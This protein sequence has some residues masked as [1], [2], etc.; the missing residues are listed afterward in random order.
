M[1]QAWLT[2]AQWRSGV[3]STSGFLRVSRSISARI[4]FGSLGWPHSSFFGRKS[5]ARTTISPTTAVN[6]RNAKCQNI[7]GSIPQPA[8]S[9]ADDLGGRGRDVKREAITETQD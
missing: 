9:L 2:R 5:H 3:A 6:V 8:F 7:I 4:S 1:R